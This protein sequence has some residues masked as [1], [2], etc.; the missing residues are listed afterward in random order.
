MC[1]RDRS[2]G[3]RYNKN[4]VVIE[5][6]RD[7]TCTDKITTW[8]ENSGK[9][10]IVYD[11]TANTMTIRMTEN[12]LAEIN[13]ATT[14]SV[15][16]THLMLQAGRDSVADAGFHCNVCIVEDGGSMLIYVLYD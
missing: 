11:D 12:G 2:K 4:D 15:S 10:A 14:V 16:Y 7:A 6:F 13:E 5:F 8:N 3:I 1:I 9:F